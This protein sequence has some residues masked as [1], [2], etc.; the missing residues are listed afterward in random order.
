MPE[1]QPSILIVDDEPLARG[2]LRELLADIALDLPHRLVGE[3]GD[4]RQ[5]LSLIESTE[6]Q[7]ILLDVQM[8]GMSG[9]ELARH[10][11]ALGASQTQRMP[12][13]VFVTAHDE[14]ALEAFEVEAV[15]YLLKPVRA[16]RLL[17]ALRRALTR[18]P[19][20]QVQAIDRIAQATDTRRRHLSVHERGRV[21]L[22]PI[23]DILYLKAELKYVTVRTAERE[24]LIEEALS[25]LEEEFG[26]WFVRI[27]RNALVARR[28]IAGFERVSQEGKEDAGDPFWQVVLRGI[29]ERLP[30]SRRQWSAI[31]N[32]VN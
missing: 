2:R 1:V 7:I 10:I 11:A 26:E 31:K 4:A 19:S 30:V 18:L 25:A 15:D 28:A 23:E 12:V 9:I 21:V 13:V 29:P 8:P 22:I 24:F 27:H 20:E 5:A 17:G 6:P 14:F 32:I 3:A 16:N